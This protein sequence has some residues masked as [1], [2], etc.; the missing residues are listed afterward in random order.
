MLRS[1]TRAT[2]TWVFGLAATILFISL[3]GRAVVVDTDALAEAAAPLA[4]SVAVV[5]L[6]T[7]WLGS[8]LE[9]NGVDPSVAVPAIEYVLETTEVGLAIDQFVSE[10]VMA[11]AWPGPQAA[12]VDIADLLAPVVPEIADTLAAAGLAI[13]EADV[14]ALIDGLDPMVVRPADAKPYVGDGSPIATRLGTAAGLALLVMAVAGW[15]AII[16]SEDRINETRRLLTRFA[17]G[18]LTFGILL[19]VGSWVLDPVGGRAPVSES[20][21]L[22]VVSKW[23]VPV[24]IASVALALAAM[25]WAVRRLLRPEAVS[26]IPA[27]QSTPE[28]EPHLSLR[29]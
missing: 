26:P 8:E 12:S 2:S 21:S 20:L 7:G 3:W 14:D 25:V 23:L 16:A 22:L 18:G 10:V 6:F 27:E 24:S 17:L 9:D 13:D 11:A 19:R 28:P 4:E 15:L 1:T 5:D 29:G